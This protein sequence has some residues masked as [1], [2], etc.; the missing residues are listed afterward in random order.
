MATT[1]DT[2]DPTAAGRRR[3]RP[4]GHRRLRVRRV[5][6]ARSRPNC[7]RCSSGWASPRS[8]GI[9]SKNVTLHRQGDIN[10]I[11]NAE[12]DSFAQGFAR[13]ARPLRL[14]NGLSRQR[15]YVAHWSSAVG[16]GAKRGARRRR[17]DGAQHPGHRG[18]RRQP[19]LSGRSLRRAHHLRRR[20]RVRG[21]RWQRRI[22]R[23]STALTLHRPSDPQRAPR[24]HGQLGGV[25]RAAVQLPRDPLFRHRRQA[26]RTDLAGDDQPVRQDPHSASTNR[27][28]TRAR[29]RS[30]LQ[31][32]HGE[33][34][35]HI[36][37]GT[38]DIYRHCRRA[39]RARRRSAG[40]HARH[41][42]RRRRRARG[43]P[44]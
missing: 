28:T 15:R 17:A 41:L 26:D 43:R 13:N 34:I 30:I 5:C 38:G 22:R 27:R 29:S 44:R 36:A 9:A 4:D 14:R 18:H 6:G 20:F 10:F 35:Q 21:R 23:S 3:R 7:A 31:D 37:L 11:I 2:C 32:Y 40:R 1:H 19:D 12:P 42:L 8:R 16:S 39:A 25:L 33:G 24:Q